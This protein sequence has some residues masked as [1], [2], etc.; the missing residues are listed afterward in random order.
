M[1]IKRNK[2]IAKIKNTIILLTG[3]LITAVSF[4][5]F[6]EPYDLVVYDSSGLAIIIKHFFKID[7]SICIAIFL[8]LCLVIGFIFLGFKDTKNAIIGSL[9][10]PIFV[11]LTENIG[12]IVTFNNPD[13]LVIALFAGI[14]TGF[15]SGLIFKSGFNTG[16]T[17][18]LELIMQK[19]MKIPFAK[20]MLIIDGAIVLAGGLVFGYELLFYALII[21][22]LIAIISDNILIGVKEN[23]AFYVIS[24]R[25]ELIER[26]LIEGLKKGVTVFEVTSGKYNE[27]KEMLYC[28]VTSSDYFSVK[29][30]I[31]SIDP[32]AFII[33]TETHETLGTKKV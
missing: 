20:A 15:G 14:T 19:Y 23:K 21:L 5:L 22:I 6:F 18:I 3:I 25:K 17:D 11:K 26:F 29:E 31:Q 28:V 4:N 33:I 30:G 24:K 10:Y 13:M 8:I 1:I 7:P 9:T 16:G 12:D 27:N 2:K 32:N